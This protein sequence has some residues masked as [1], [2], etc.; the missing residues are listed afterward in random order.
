MNKI[1]VMTIFGT[2]PE[3]IKM[4]PLVNEL[5]R[6]K[7][8][9][10]KVCVTA[11][12]REMLDQVL[13]IFNL[14]PDY[15]LNIMKNKQTLSTITTSVLNGLDKI[16]AVEKPNLVLV[17]GD[18]TTTFAASLS[19]FYNK[20]KIGHVEAGLRTYNKYSPFPEEANR[21]LTG[22]I[23]DLHFAPT[24]TSKENLLKEAIDENSIFITGNTVIDAMAST[25][26][27]DYVFENK[28]L[29]KIDFKNKKV[30]MVTAHR[31]ENWGKPL[32]NICN[33][34]KSLALE[35]KDVEIVY[36]VHL[37]PVVQNTAKEILQNIPNVHLLPPLDLKET[38][39]LMNKSYLIMTDSGGIQEE[40]PHLG[41]PVLVLRDTTE[42]PEAV[43]AGTVKIV[44]T[45][46]DIILKLSNE[47]ITNREEY[48][49][50]SNSV[51]P[52]G[53]GR[54]SQRIVDNILFNFGY[55]E[56]RPTD[57]QTI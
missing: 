17:H 45:H 13:D 12:H 1:K 51:N 32:E 25:V 54:A 6:K 15:D 47:L 4:C 42:R 57:F 49:K 39:N 52:Y 53:D 22:H 41:K 14:T 50:M 2:R 37:N 21:V 11:Q 23:A 40:A 24:K 29:N 56:N 28:E 5:K 10:C 19:A 3:A 48:D 8:I 7:E 30:I 9:D 20:I 43:K 27:E 35:H 44:G 34:L 31:R 38:H 16:F 36:L 26:E 18:T 46:M 33:S 55:I